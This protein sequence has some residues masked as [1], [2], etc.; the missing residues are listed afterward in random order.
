M[1]ERWHKAMKGIGYAESTTVGTK[2]IDPEELVLQIEQERNLFDFE[3]ERA[4][5]LQAEVER[6]RARILKLVDEAENPE[7]SAAAGTY[8]HPVYAKLIRAA[9]KGEGVSTETENH[10]IRK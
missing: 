10:G 1:M 2:V 6:L 9:L 7:E 5:H 4:E 3:F 8:I